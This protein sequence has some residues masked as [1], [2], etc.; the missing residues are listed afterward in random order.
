M[1]RIWSELLDVEDIRSDDSFF[2]LG[3]HS[4]L[5]LKVVERFE[6]A[7]GRRIR[8]VDLVN[9][10]LGQLVASLEARAAADTAAAAPAARTARLL[11]SVKNAFSRDT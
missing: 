1:A 6:R 11:Q 3:G 9:Q 4:L 7:T 8:P 2:D 5:S 10:T